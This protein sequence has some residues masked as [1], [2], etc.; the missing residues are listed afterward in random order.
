VIC[1]I[2]RD[3]KSHEGISAKA[4]KGVDQHEAPQSTP[5][6]MQNRQAAKKLRNAQLHVGFTALPR[7]EQ[8]NS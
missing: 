7:G 3:F 4:K 5:S 2:S 8:R 1:T 6:R